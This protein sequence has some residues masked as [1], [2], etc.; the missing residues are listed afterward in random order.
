MSLADTYLRNGL[1]DHAKE[2]WRQ[3]IR[4]YPGSAQARLAAEL[5]GTR[6]D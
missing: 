2:I 4:E 3:V 6:R 1:P 5:L